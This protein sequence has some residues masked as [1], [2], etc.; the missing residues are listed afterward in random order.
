VGGND[1]TLA[2][3]PYILL[4]LSILVYRSLLLIYRVLVSFRLLG[5]VQR[6]RMGGLGFK[7][8]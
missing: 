4:L 1:W 2:N 7:R 5:F 6:H 8:F 3:I